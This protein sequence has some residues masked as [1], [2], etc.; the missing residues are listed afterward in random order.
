MNFILK[1]DLQNILL[2]H[3]CLTSLGSP[4]LVTCGAHGIVLTCTVWSYF[5]EPFLA[6][7]GILLAFVVDCWSKQEECVSRKRCILTANLAHIWFGCL[8]V[9]EYQ[10]VFLSLSAIVLC[11]MVLAIWLDSHL[12]NPQQFCLFHFGDPVYKMNATTSATEVVCWKPNLVLD[13]TYSLQLQSSEAALCVRC[14]YS[15][16]CGTISSTNEE[17]VKNMPNPYSIGHG[18][19][20]L[21]CDA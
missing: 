6:R 1:S 20:E 4:L 12:G 14:I 10:M 15:W 9:A 3:L 18:A 16:G 2:A 21:H 8:P 17:F 13:T 7:N 5:Y 19:C 11:F